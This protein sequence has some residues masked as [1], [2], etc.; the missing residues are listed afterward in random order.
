MPTAAPKT[1]R[2]AVVQAHSVLLDLPATLAKAD[3]LI[4]QAA[5][6][7][8]R[9]IVF[10]EAFI[11]GYPRGLGFGTIVGSRAPSAAWVGGSSEGRKCSSM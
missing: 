1:V 4:K 2:V 9:I 5:S 7:G 3:M 6:E 10:P 8:A 11:G